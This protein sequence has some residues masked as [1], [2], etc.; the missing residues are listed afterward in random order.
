MAT[1]RTKLRRHRKAYGFSIYAQ[2]KA[3]GL[4][5]PTT[6]YNIERKISASPYKAEELEWRIER[7]T[8]ANPLEEA[9][10]A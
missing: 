1:I 9:A 7:H 5:N 10:N 4:K 3:L 2:A 6:L 8:T